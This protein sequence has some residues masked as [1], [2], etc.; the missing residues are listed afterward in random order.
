M[1]WRHEEVVPSCVLLALLQVRHWLLVGFVLS[2]PFIGICCLPAIFLLHMTPVRLPLK[3]WPCMTP[4]RNQAVMPAPFLMHLDVKV[5]L[6]ISANAAE[7]LAVSCVAVH[8][9]MT[10]DAI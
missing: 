7:T 8:C 5:F 3:Q 6:D 9:L 10:S 1:R 2:L 4:F